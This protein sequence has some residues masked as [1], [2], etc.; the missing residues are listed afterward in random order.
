V[1]PDRDDWI[2]KPTQP[3]DGRFHQAISEF[4]YEWGASAPPGFP[5]RPG[6]RRPAVG[7]LARAA[8]PA[9]PQQHP[10]RLLLRRLRAG[11]TAARLGRRDRRA[12]A[13]GGAVRRPGAGR[14][15]QR[16]GRRRP[17]GQDPTPRP[18]PTT[19]PWSGRARPA[20]PGRA[21]GLRGAP[22]HRPGARGHRRP[23]RHQLQDP[24]RT[25]LSQGR[26]R[27]RAGGT[28]LP[29]GVE[30][31]SD[32]VYGQCAVDLRAAGPTE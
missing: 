6:H 13:G 2:D 14:P 5:G 31:R 11:P 7:P 12:A 16:R 22:D 4:L 1:L 20:W 21:R 18:S 30:L 15:V 19:S 23:G 28:G 26:Q 24:Q 29:A 17:G 25:W 3:G 9:E 8:G 32:F 27:R 10:V